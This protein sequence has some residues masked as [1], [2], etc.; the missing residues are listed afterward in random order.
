MNLNTDFYHI[1]WFF[2]IYCVCGWLWESSFC[3]IK[4]KKWINRGF[5]MGPYIPIYGCGA[6]VVYLT[7]YPLKEDLW[8]VYMGGV[9][10]PTIL[11]FFTSWLMEKL[12]AATWWDYS[13]EKFNIQGRIC[14]KVSLFWGF[15]SVFMVEILHP[16]VLILIDKLP[17]TAG[18][19]LGGLFVVVFSA[20]FMNTVV[21]TLDVKKTL[22]K[23]ENIRE[24]IFQFL[25]VHNLGPEYRELSPSH[26]VSRLKEQWEERK[27]YFEN[28][29]LTGTINEY[30]EELEDKL[31]VL[32]RRY[33]ENKIKHRGVLQRHM[34]AY[35]NLKS[36]RYAKPME[37]MKKRLE[38]LRKEK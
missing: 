6:L 10:F 8:L 11:E 26:M 16:I 5:L 33:E 2:I 24:D 35:P 20:D 21:A 13:N 19:V 3:S 4:A 17:R 38:K 12:F 23:M 37:D 30:R 29:P 28:I 34:K 14:L 31:S 36:S 32:V 18:Q 15:F 22:E 7:L 1:L 9:V 25:D 27:E